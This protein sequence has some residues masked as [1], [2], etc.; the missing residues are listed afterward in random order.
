MSDKRVGDQPPHL[1]AED[2]RRLVEQAVPRQVAHEWVFHL[3]FCPECRKRLADG[4][5]ARGMAL[6][7]R[8]RRFPVLQAQNTSAAPAPPGNWE[9]LSGAATRSLLAAYRLCYQEEEEAPP[10]YRE[11]IRHPLPRQELLLDN[12]RRYCTLG[13]LKYVLSRTPEHWH[14]DPEAAES[15]ARL[16][17]AVH[18]RLAT[19]R[20]P[21]RLVADFGA[22]AW[23]SLANALRIRSDLPAADRAMDRAFQEIEHGTG[24]A[25]DR[26]CLLQLRVS[27]R[28]AQRRLQ[29]ARTDALHATRLWR[30]VG[31][32]RAVTEAILLHSSI[33]FE[34]GDALE[35]I[36]TL[37]KCLRRLDE[38]EVGTRLY[39]GVVQNLAFR[40]AQANRSGE[41]SHYIPE[42]RELAAG[43][44][45]PLSEIRVDWLEALV[46]AGH[47]RTPRAVIRFNHLLD[48]FLAY[49][50]PYDAALVGLDLATVYLE[51]GDTAAARALAGKLVPIFQSLQIERE[52]AEALLLFV[53]ALRKEAATVAMA[54]KVKAMLRR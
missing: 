43:L 14:R 1:G 28:R 47:G 6:L 26:A 3:L 30:S 7:A 16:A 42:L 32:R 49:R 40:L 17:L 25:I 48:R 46:D 34:A 53:E 44:G 38:A 29:E 5:P 8:V 35:A 51:A 31:D 27:L 2:L 12:S 19:D 50:M 15:H 36:A 52:A 13:L 23:A 9:H 21:S 22:R 24:D 37:R 4:F 41:A 11:L 33:L 54:E 39:F 18:C 10:L 20:Y 45:E